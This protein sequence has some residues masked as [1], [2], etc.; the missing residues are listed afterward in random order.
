MKFLTL[1]RITVYAIASLLIG[2]AVIVTSLI[3]TP[4]RAS[5]AVDW[6]AFYNSGRIAR[7]EPARLYDPQLQQELFSDVAPTI[8]PRL[9]PYFA[10]TPF[11]SLVFVPLSFLPY[12][13]AFAAW[14]VL[15]IAM[16]LIGLR[17]IWR[18]T[19]LPAEHF[20][21]AAIFSLCF[22]PFYAWTLFMGQTTAFALF[23][24]A[25]AIYFERTGRMLISGLAL[26]LLLYKPPLLIL[27][28]PMLLIT[29]RWRSVKGFATGGCTLGLISLALIGP[30]GVP[31]YVAMMRSFANKKQGL[32]GLTNIEVDAYSFL[33][34][35][36]H[37]QMRLATILWIALLGI[38]GYWLVKTWR[39]NKREAWIPTI[40]WTCVLNYYVLLY[41]SSLIILS[42]VLLIASQGHVSKT[43]RW[44]LIATFVVPWFHGPMSRAWG[45][46][47]MTVMLIAL[48][49]Y[50]LYAVLTRG[51]P[52]ANQSR[53]PILRL[54]MFS[55][56]LL[57][58]HPDGWYR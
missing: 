13:L 20:K 24:L 30:S 27:I 23:A 52:V 53:S 26:S 9:V 11:F 22:L 54:R 39:Q 8:D 1:E 43:L 25:L 58:C 5:G 29:K 55:K 17:L 47:P 2:S 48:G 4:A 35:L 10:Y 14:I 16:L 50:Q 44:L 31:A 56:L 46:Q 32:S 40:T 45:F 33:V 18:T 3:Q 42:A 15:C 37:G 7:S 12:L 49:C 41:D 28:I 36:T 6:P 21:Y 57:P 19:N 34:N 51:I 38:V